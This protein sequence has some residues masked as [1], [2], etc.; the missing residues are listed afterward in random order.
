MKH[1]KGYLIIDENGKYV[2]GYVK[3]N[4]ALRYIAYNKSEKCALRPFK[5]K[6][7]V[8]RYIEQLYKIANSLGEHRQ[9]TYKEIWDIKK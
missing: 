5:T 6:Q 9:F 4:I 2:V 7:E 1:T 3:E 8:V